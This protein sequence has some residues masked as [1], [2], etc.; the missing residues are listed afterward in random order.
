MIC[1]WIEKAA[2]SMGHEISQLNAVQTETIVDAIR[3]RFTKHV[4]KSDNIWEDFIDDVSLKCEDGWKIACEFPEHEPILIFR[5]KNSYFGYCISST[6][7]MKHLLGEC[8]GFEF[9]ITNKTVNFVLCFNHHDYLI[10]VGECKKW[11]KM[12]ENIKS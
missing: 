5:D 10:G 2:C 3:K 9:Y 7:L 6:K 1:K 8:P 11:I 4:N 12:I